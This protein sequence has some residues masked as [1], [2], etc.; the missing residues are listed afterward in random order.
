MARRLYLKTLLIYSHFGLKKT[1]V[2]LAKK[3]GALFLFC[4]GWTQRREKNLAM[5]LRL[6]LSLLF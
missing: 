1:S 6:A 5:T 2:V 4:F 3:G